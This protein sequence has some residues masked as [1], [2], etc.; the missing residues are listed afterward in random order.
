L[1]GVLVI[2]KKEMKD[3]FSSVRF[4]LI[5]ALI[6]M[7][8]IIIASVVGMGI[9]KEV[10][11]MP[12]PTLLFLYLFTSTGKLFSFVQFIAFFGPLLGIILGFD[13]ISKEKASRTLSKL[14]S[15]PI[16]RDAII[17]GKFLAGVVTVGVI[18][19][20][21]MLVITGIGIQVLGF[22][23]GVQEILRLII[24]LVVAV[25]YISF[26]LAISI[27]F[28][29]VFRSTSTS[30]LAGIALWIF[31]SFLVGLGASILADTLT[32]VYQGPEGVDV[33]SYVNHERMIRYVSYISPA[34]LYADSTS[35]IL[36]PMRN[37]TSAAV[38]MG[39][40]ERRSMERF[41]SPLPVSQSLLIVGPHVIFLIGITLLC[42]GICY[43]LFM[44]QEIRAV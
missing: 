34:S 8:G 1:N 18:L 16:Y 7:V 26:W 10:E 42:F 6:M 38:L 20:A 25:V 32:P 4:I 33:V 30:A 17:N 11:G 23:P 37:T 27:L 19:S 14:V 5:S 44:K 22:A 43:V 3:H 35:T 9:Q 40:M 28:S 2:F 31:C 12:K 39:P 41:Q 15:Q 29:T 13:A 21:I 36:D 24:Y